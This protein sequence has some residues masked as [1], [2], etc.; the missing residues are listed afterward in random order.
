MKDY[1]DTA[2]K[3]I[4]NRTQWIS[5]MRLY[6]IYLLQLLQFIGYNIDSEM[7]QCNGP[8]AI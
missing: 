8:S 1:P 7:Y 2:L 5:S 6:R 4:I 3:V